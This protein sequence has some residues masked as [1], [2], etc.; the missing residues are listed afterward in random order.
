M[1]ELT[2][3]LV[4]DKADFRIGCDSRSDDVVLRTSVCA[5]PGPDARLGEPDR[6]VAPVPAVGGRSSEALDIAAP[7]VRGIFPVSSSR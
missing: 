3:G 2:S 7:E 4:F 5:T 6:V 1:S